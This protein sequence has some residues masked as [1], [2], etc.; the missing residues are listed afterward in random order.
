MRSGVARLRGWEQRH[1]LAADL[2]LAV[3]LG[4]AA[5]VEL[6]AVR[7]QVE[8]PWWGQALCFL[9]M[10]ASVALRRRAV[11]VAAAACGSALVVQEALGPAPVV[12][13]FLALLV[14]LYSGG[15]HGPGRQGPASLIVLLTALTVYPVTESSARAPGD[16]VGNL[17][18]F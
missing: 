11:V 13:G 8:G 7:E 5:V 12:S 18:I 9:V 14:V 10:T 6:T 15:A 2:A 3:V 4:A 17:A 16:L 1:W